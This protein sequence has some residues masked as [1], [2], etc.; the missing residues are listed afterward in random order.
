MTNMPTLT[1]TTRTRAYVQIPTSYNCANSSW[2][3]NEMY[4]TIVLRQPGRASVPYRNRQ[5]KRLCY[6]TYQHC[7]YYCCCTL[8]PLLLPLPLFPL[9]SLPISLLQVVTTDSTSS[10]A[11]LHKQLQHMH[12]N[13]DLLTGSVRWHTAHN[14]SILS[15]N[16]TV[17]TEAVRVSANGCC[18]IRQ[19]ASQ[20][21]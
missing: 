12:Y 5:M 6:R 15:S 8:S 1:F 14:N 20:L 21:T 11:H 18:H 9:L 4:G 10:A 7:Y 3:H 19:Y 16:V 2:Y 17:T 13:L